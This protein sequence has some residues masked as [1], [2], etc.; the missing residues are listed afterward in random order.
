MTLLKHN[1]SVMYSTKPSLQALSYPVEVTT[2]SFIQLSWQRQHNYYVTKDSIIIILSMKTKIQLKNHFPNV[3]TL[4][5][6]R[7]TV[8]TIKVIL[9]K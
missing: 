5:Y 3:K 8:N 6:K 7:A 4:A 1:S 2:S 9:T